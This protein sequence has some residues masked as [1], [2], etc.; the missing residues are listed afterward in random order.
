MSWMEHAQ[1]LLIGAVLFVAS[2]F[3]VTLSRPDLSSRQSYKE[4]HS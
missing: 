1:W 3:V 4:K 2:L